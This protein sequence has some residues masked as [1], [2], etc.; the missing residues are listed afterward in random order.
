MFVPVVAESVSAA[1]QGCEAVIEVEVEGAVVRVSRA[2][3]AEL[4]T[5]V[6]QALRVPR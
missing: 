6:V 2:A 1:S 3:S 4:V 5:A